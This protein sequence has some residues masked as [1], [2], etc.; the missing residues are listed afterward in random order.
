MSAKILLPR[1]VLLAGLLGLS[2]VHIAAPAAAQAARATTPVQ[3]AKSAADDLPPISYICTMPGDEA[4]L[5][6]KPGKCPNPKC[7]MELKPIRIVRAYSC[8][9]N[10]AF[11][12]ENPGKCRTDG[13]DLV[14]INVSMFWSCPDAPDKRELTPGKCADGKDRLKKYEP[15]PHG[16]HNPRHGGQLFMASDAWH[17]IEGAY[18]SAGLFRVFFYDDWTKPLAPKGFTARAVVK[19]VANKEVATVPLKAGRIANTMDGQIPGAKLP[20]IVSLRVSF[21]PGESENL[22][23]FQ[24]N[25]YT[26]EPVAPAATL[27]KAQ[28][29]AATQAPSRSPSA[30]QGQGTAAT[31]QPASPPV[32]APPPVTTPGGLK[33]GDGTAPEFVSAFLP[34]E[35]P[36]PSTS[37]EILVQ[38]EASEKQLAAEIAEGA[39]LGQLWVPALR[40]KNLALALVNDHLTELPSQQRL[41]CESAVNRLLRAAFAID[42]FGDLGA[43]DKIV[44]VHGVFAE[45]VATLKA[46]YASV[47]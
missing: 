35:A 17:H 18:P 41:L 16:D 45:S 12:Q 44:A 24:F 37:K 13:T 9:N 31:A 28:P 40:G 10:T 33:P 34:Q 25:E 30:G 4:I 14:P 6:D 26:K 3:Q 8:L 21:K 27:T 20:L 47:R 22:F 11:I 15:R 23:D 32:A 38:L 36:I 1:V 39:P 7:G 42:N 46:A 5:E 19:D 43:K 2:A 29:A